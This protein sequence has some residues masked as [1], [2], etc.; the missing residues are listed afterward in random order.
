MSEPQGAAESES[1]ALPSG[2]LLVGARDGGARGG[3]DVALDA[4]QWSTLHARTMTLDDLQRVA[5]IE[6]R[7]Y[8]FPWTIG[9]FADSLS[10][11]YDCWVF[12]VQTQRSGYAVLM[13]I[14]DEVHLLNLSVDEPLQ[15]RG[16]GR[17]MLRWLCAE[18]RTRGAQGMLLEVRPSNEPAVALYVSMGFERIGVRKRYYP[19]S[20][21][22]R[23]DAWVMLY[24]LADGA[25]QG[26]EAADGEVKR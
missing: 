19:A 22:T 12:E 26:Q 23:E 5:E 8:P 11:G 15:G 4:G 6:A 24:K 14:A 25:T 18:A 2:A 21:G 1:A 17:A 10:A 13:W 20:E 9:N 16:L 7:I 3:V